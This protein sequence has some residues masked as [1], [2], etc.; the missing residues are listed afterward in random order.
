MNRPRPQRP[1]SDVANLAQASFALEAARQRFER[2]M[3]TEARA[4]LDAAAR[5]VLRASR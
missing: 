3:T 5:W 1:L 2:E 4:E